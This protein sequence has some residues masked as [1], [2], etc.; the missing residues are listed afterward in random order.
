MPAHHYLL[1]PAH[2]CML[3]PAHHYLLVPAHHY[4]LVP[5]HHYMLV[6]AHHCLPTTACPLLLPATYN[7][8]CHAAASP[9]ADLL[10]VAHL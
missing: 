10:T 6:P 1:V 9:P 2:H 8:A 5:A 4:L 7:A 3:V